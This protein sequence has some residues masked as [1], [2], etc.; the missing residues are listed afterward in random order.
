MTAAAEK[1]GRDPLYAEAMV[2]PDIEIEGL[3]TTGRPLDFRATQAMEYGYAEAIAS[4][5]GRSI[6]VSGT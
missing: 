3:T 5:M 6:G 2:D 4:N 1:N